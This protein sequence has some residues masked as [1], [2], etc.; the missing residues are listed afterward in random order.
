M[1]VDASGRF[2]PSE[3]RRMMLACLR[4]WLTDRHTAQAM[5]DRGF[6]PDSMFAALKDAE[7][8]TD[9]ELA[10]H[11]CAMLGEKPVRR[12]IANHTG[13]HLDKSARMALRDLV[14]LRRDL[15][16]EYGIG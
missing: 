7:A 15:R 8:M 4:N 10:L 2:Y 13:R 5:A 14:R 12:A 3:S 9:K 11:L 1:L 6:M 16:Q